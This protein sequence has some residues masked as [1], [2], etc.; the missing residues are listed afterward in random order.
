MVLYVCTG[1]GIVTYL[2]CCL[3]S[4]CA[5]VKAQSSHNIYAS[6][7]VVDETDQSD[8]IVHVLRRRKT[9]DDIVL[10][11]KSSRVRLSNI[12]AYSLDL[13]RHMHPSEAEREFHYITGHIVELLSHCHPTWLIE[14]CRQLMASEVHKIRLFQIDYIQKLRNLKSSPAALKMLSVFWSWSNHSI[15]TFLAQFSELAVALLEDFDSELKLFHPITHY[16]FL[17]AMEIPC[18]DNYTTL[19][20]R[21]EDELKV[22][23]QVVYDIQS[24]LIEKCEITQYALQLVAVHEDPIMLQWMIPFCLVDLI[25]KNVDHHV[26]YFALKGITDILVRPDEK[27]CINYNI[28]AGP[29]IIL[30]REEVRAFYI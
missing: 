21:C 5:V 1:I 24:A 6:V 25:N 23:L 26:Q 11:K 4:F 17:S 27:Y 3:F 7:I 14:R 30:S 28:E 10:F 18:D 8:D 2:Y 20:L 15:L 12:L 29:M 13:V 16:T 22:T 19:T 9:T